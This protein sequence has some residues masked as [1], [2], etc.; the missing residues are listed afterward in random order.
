MHSGASYVI[1]SYLFSVFGTLDN[2]ACSAESS[3]LHGGRILVRSS[4][5]FPAVI[6]TLLVLHLLP[7]SPIICKV[8]KLK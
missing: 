6:S 2:I 1:N 4:E 7:I 5:L 3:M 8:Q